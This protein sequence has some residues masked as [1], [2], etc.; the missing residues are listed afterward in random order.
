MQ[1]ARR[2]RD[3]FVYISVR[4]LKD[5]PAL[6][7]LEEDLRQTDDQYLSQ[8]VARRAADYFTLLD[9]LNN[10]SR[11]AGLVIDPEPKAEEV[12]NTMAMLNAYDKYG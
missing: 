10:M 6:K 1:G 5:S 12:D 11:P 3:R 9:I 2:N 8:H 7:R 4:F